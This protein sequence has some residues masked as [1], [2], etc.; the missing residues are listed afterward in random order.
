MFLLQDN[1]YNA[2]RM[3]YAVCIEKEI[4]LKYGYCFHLF[5]G[6]KGSYR[7]EKKKTYDIHDVVGT[8]NA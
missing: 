1:W 4:L 6:I 7:F 2:T 8:Y 3:E 5:D